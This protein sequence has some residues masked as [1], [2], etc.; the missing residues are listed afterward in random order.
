MQNG[1][2]EEARPRQLAF[3]L[4]QN[5]KSV[6]VLQAARIVNLELETARALNVGEQR[7]ANAMRG[8]RV[9][10]PPQPTVEIGIDL[11]QVGRQLEAV[12]KPFAVN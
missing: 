5:Y 1:P 3:N 10:A 12:Q 2:I 9:E 8:E 11:G 6:C 4:Q 7:G